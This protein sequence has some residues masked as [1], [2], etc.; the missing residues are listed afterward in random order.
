M[1]NNLF[2]MAFEAG[3]HQAAHEVTQGHIRVGMKAHVDPVFHRPDRAVPPRFG[4]LAA[5]HFNVGQEHSETDDQIRPF[6]PPANAGWAHGTDVDAH[7]KGVVHRESAFCQHG[8]TAGGA[9]LFDELDDFARD[10]EAIGFDADQYQR[11]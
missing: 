1:I 7:I 2:P 3:A 9:Y 11:M 8:S 6:D 10:L 4:R 5:A